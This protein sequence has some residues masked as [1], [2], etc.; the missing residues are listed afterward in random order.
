M[1]MSSFVRVVV[2]SCITLLT[3]RIGSPG[4]LNLSLT[5]VTSFVKFDKMRF[6][7]YNSALNAVSLYDFGN[8]R[9]PWLW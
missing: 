5:N 6:S 9:R 8:I 3:K 7:R 1:M 2:N 4:E